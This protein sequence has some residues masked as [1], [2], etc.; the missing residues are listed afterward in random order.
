MT[1]ADSGMERG[2]LRASPTA[3]RTERREEEKKSLVRMLGETC[4]FRPVNSDLSK[5][6][7]LSKMASAGPELESCTRGV[8]KSAGRWMLGWGMAWHSR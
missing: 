6:L 5:S 4:Q 1:L 7:S 8:S 3:S 2:A